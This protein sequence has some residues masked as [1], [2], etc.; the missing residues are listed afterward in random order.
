MR[1]T[2]DMDVV[3]SLPTSRTGGNAGKAGKALA[4]TQCGLAR[5]RCHMRRSRDTLYRCR[6]RAPSLSYL[7]RLTLSHGIVLHRVAP[8]DVSGMSEN[9]ST[10]PSCYPPVV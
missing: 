1:L 7:V 5:R 2:G 4:L 8:V 10:S 3:A 6:R 9:V